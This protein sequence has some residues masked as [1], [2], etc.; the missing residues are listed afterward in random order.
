MRGELNHDGTTGTAEVQFIFL[1]SSRL[2]VRQPLLKSHA[3]ARRRKGIQ[4]QLLLFLANL[5]GSKNY[6]VILLF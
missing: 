5:G 3:K 2:C 6:F 4:M 1:I